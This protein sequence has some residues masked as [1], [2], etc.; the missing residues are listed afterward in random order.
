MKKISGLFIIVALLALS[1]CFDTVQ[2]ATI[3]DDGSGLYVSTMDMGK[4]LGMIKM[5][6]GEKAEMKD[7]DKMKKDTT[8]YLKDIKDSIKNLTD[9]E[10][11]LMDKG[12][13]KVIMNMP[14]EIF[15][16][17]FSFP[18]SQPA[19]L[20]T[21]SNLLKKTRQNVMSDQMDKFMGGDTTGTDKKNA[22]DDNPLLGD[23]GSDSSNT[24]VGDYYKYKYEKGKISKKLNKEMYANVENDKSLTSLKEMSQMGLSTTMKTIINLPR[25]AKK[26]EGKGVKLSNDRKKVTIEGSLDDFFEDAAYFEYEIEY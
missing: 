8:I 4:L 26:A 20:A 1:G 13:L 14:D 25:P 22:M 5:V 6:A 16:M 10:K 7:L 18:Y 23:L 2:E 24:E 3:N 17:A 21:I 12:T 11:K 15:S 9:A 19:D